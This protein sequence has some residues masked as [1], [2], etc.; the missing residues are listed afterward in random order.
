MQLGKM[1]G[2]EGFEPRKVDTRLR[3]NHNAPPRAA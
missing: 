3:L 1:V 2:R